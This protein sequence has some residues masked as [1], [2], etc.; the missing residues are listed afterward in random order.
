M[1]ELASML[2]KWSPR[3][4][5]LS[6]KLWQLAESSNYACLPYSGG[7]LNQ[8]EWFIDDVTHFLLLQEWHELNVQLPKNDKLKPMPD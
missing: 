3:G 4:G 5:L 7:W 6:Y 1:Q 8:P 2:K